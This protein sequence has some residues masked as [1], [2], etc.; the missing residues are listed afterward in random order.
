MKF[1]NLDA[2]EFIPVYFRQSTYEEMY[3]SIVYPINCENMWQITPYNDMLPP[4]KEYCQGGK[5]RRL[6]E[7]ELVRDETRMR[8]GDI[9][10]RC[11]IC[12]NLCHNRTS[13]QKSTQ[14][15]DVNPDQTQ[16]SN[17]ANQENI[18]SSNEP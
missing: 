1:M 12:K 8:K 4:K 15:G 6:Q 7:W 5:K 17:P 16:Q 2:E 9:Q 10:K 11:G 14:E 18:P 13:C 3:S